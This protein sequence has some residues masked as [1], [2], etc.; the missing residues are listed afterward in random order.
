MDKD[1]AQNICI[2][3][4]EQDIDLFEIAGICL[5]AKW[6]IRG[7][8][9]T[10][11]LLGAS[12]AFLATPIYNSAEATLS[13][14]DELRGSAPANLGGLTSFARLDLVN[15]TDST[16]HLSERALFVGAN[17]IYIVR[18]NPEI[19]AGVGV[20]WFRRRPAVEVRPGAIVGAPLDVDRRMALG[21]WSSVTRIV[22]NIAIEIAA[23]NSF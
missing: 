11:A 13:P 6:I 8:A 20:N 21:L 15:S 1:P 16:E 12:S 22:Y 9:V 2:S 5:R 23:V 19:A 7:I 17:R 4:G 3:E 14:N 10:V 18:A